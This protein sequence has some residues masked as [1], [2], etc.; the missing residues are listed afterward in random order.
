MLDTLRQSG[1]RIGHELGRAWENIS[2]GWHELIN[3]SAQALTQFTR[4]KESQGDADHPLA[5]FPRWSLLA[6]EVEETGTEIV[7]RLELPGM[8]KEDCRI[9]VDGNVLYVSGEKH[10]E[11]SSH[12]S[13][14]HVMERAYGSFRRTIALPG[15]VL[16]DKASASYTNG[17][18]SIRLPKASGEKPRFITVT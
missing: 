2:E 16:A 12:D 7:V 10:V 18:M 15:E 11:Y 17:V 6:G 8:R 9:T 4:A 13:R 1:K 3:R 14:Y 5:D